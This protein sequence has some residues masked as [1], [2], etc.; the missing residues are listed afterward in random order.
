MVDKR[1]FKS[2]LKDENNKKVNAK[3]ASSSV[4]GTSEQIH[5]LI[6]LAHCSSFESASSS[7]QDL[8]FEATKEEFNKRKIAFSEEKYLSLGLRDGEKN[9][10]TNLAFL[11]SDQCP[12][13]V[14]VAVFDD[15]N[16]T[17]FIDRREFP[18]S[19]F[20]QLHDT[21]D[22]L[23]LNNRTRS[24]ISGLDRHDSMD[25]PPEAIREALLNALIHRDYAYS[26]SIIIN[27]NKER[28]EFI[29][30]GG[31]PKGLS[32]NDIK[33]GISLPRNAKLAQFFSL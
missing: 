2:V 21:F 30:I 20:K 6:K 25:Y 1:D 10:F 19:L 15:P 28:M 26:G 18:G 9:L 12:H 24:V 29:S 8:T 17:I 11:L 3:P 14:K 27:I 16:N 13:S 33:A 5:Q 31:L 7:L 23:M 22:Y 4:Q 32:K